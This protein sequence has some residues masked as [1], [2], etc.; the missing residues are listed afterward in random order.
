MYVQYV[1][2]ARVYINVHLNLKRYLWQSHKETWLCV[3]FSFWVCEFTPRSLK[4]G[5]DT[6]LV[7]SFHCESL[8]IHPGVSTWELPPDVLHGAR[9]CSARALTRPNTFHEERVLFR[10]FASV[11]CKF[12]LAGF[13]IL[14]DMSQKYVIRLPVQVCTRLCV[15][16]VFQQRSFSLSSRWIPNSPHQH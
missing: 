16:I 7:S 9:L 8:P 6:F 14:S 5:L 12:K 15:K 4:S 1:I 11:K 2:C 13:S 3:L 10:Q